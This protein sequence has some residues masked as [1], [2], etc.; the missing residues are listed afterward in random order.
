MKKLIAVH[1][2]ILLFGVAFICSAQKD[3]KV[4]CSRKQ[5]PEWIGISSKE[6]FSVSAIAASLD[7]AQEI[8]LNDIRQ[9]IVTS[10][11]SYIVSSEQF[12]QKQVTQDGVTSMLSRYSSEVD[13]HSV[14][15]PYILGI[16]LSNAEDVY[17]EKWLSRD[18]KKY[19]YIY[20]VCYPFSSFE[21]NRAIAEFKA[22]DDSKES[23]LHALRE[24]FEVFTE[25][26]FV[27]NAASELE[28][29]E[30]YFFDNTRKSEAKALRAQYLKSLDDIVIIC[31]STKTGEWHFHFSLNG[32]NIIHDAQPVI[33]SNHAENMR[34]Q[35]K[36]NGYVLLYEPM[37]VN[38][39]ENSIF[40]RYPIGSR[41]LE[42][43]FS[44][45]YT[46]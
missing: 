28:A 8:C 4:D 23:R 26:T 16:S 6:K 19:Y 34:V 9:Y 45:H 41:G 42:H 33:R 10:I 43:H 18:T 20:H 12:S 44:F 36:V 17:W 15:L 25:T 38:T 22:M 29:L 13:T 21:R 46:E 31:D 37:G 14:G 27:R 35:K 2:V 1:I 7:E 30:T 5:R 11:A 3:K 32:R 24:S 40:F 39:E